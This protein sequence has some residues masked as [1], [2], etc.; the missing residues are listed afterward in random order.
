VVHNTDTDTTAAVSWER[1]RA[2][3][4]Y[5]LAGRP[6]IIVRADTNRMGDLWRLP[7]AAGGPLP[8]GATVRGGPA[9]SRHVLGQI[10]GRR[11]RVTGVLR[12]PVTA[13]RFLSLL[14][15]PE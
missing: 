3:V 13:W 15:P 10:A 11:I 4:Y 1:D 6:S 2:R 12:H 7:V 14:S 9:A 5:D 8:V